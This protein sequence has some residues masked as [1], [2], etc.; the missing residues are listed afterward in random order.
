MKISIKKVIIN[1]IGACIGWILSVPV[2]LYAE[3]QFIYHAPYS[4]NADGVEVSFNQIPSSIRDS[5]LDF[6]ELEMQRMNRVLTSSSPEYKDL[7]QIYEAPGTEK[8]YLEWVSF[9]WFGRTAYEIVPYSQYDGM[10]S[11]TDHKNAIYL[12]GYEYMPMIIDGDNL[13]IPQ[14]RIYSLG[15]Y[16]NVENIENVKFMKYSMSELRKTNSFFNY[17]TLLNWDYWIKNRNRE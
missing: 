1:V 17:Y 16:H 7:K 13:Y 9:A 6:R 8:Y 3:C 11:I 10:Y 12:P 14:E 5:L 4:I 15:T 2:L